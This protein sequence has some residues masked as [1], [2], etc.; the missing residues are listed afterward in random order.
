[1]YNSSAACTHNHV[2][3]VVDWKKWR[4]EEAIERGRKLDINRMI[5]V[6]SAMAVNI[7][8]SE[9]NVIGCVY[10]NVRQLTSNN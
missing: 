8:V 5:V 1:M 4:N 7:L 3:R 9:I 6:Q 10:M 2:N